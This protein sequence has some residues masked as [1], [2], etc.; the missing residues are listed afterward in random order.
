MVADRTD[1]CEMRV[2]SGR[3]QGQ[4][5]EYTATL[6]DIRK[7]RRTCRFHETWDTVPLTDI[8]TFNRFSDAIAQGYVLDDRIAG[9]YRMKRRT[10]DGWEFAS[11]ILG[12]VA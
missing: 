4:L 9:G 3:R 1:L 2:K 7:H 6:Y 8:A 10:H 12:E 5:C 11:V